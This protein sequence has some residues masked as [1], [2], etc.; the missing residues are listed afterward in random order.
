MLLIDGDILLYSSCYSSMSKNH[1]YHTHLYNL[2][3]NFIC[4]FSNNS[5][6]EYFSFLSSNEN[7]RKK[8]DKSYKN[9]RKEKPI[10][11][12]ETREFL[13]QKFNFIEYPFLEADD[14]I[15]ITK[16]KFFPDSTI[17]SIDKDLYQ[18]D[19]NHYNLRTEKKTKISIKDSENNLLKQFIIGDSVDNI[20]GLKGKGK[21]YAEN[22]L[23][24]NDSKSYKEKLRLIYELYN[25]EFLN[26]YINY[27]NL[28]LKSNHPDFENYIESMKP[29]VFDYTL[30]IE[31][32]L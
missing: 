13:K 16:R 5:D 18:I 1:D 28:K 24:N 23:K 30:P 6:K 3:Y 4:I 31:Y 20:K 2:I 7:Y 32:Y 15:N 12:Q 9:N 26:F 8:I 10:Y 27:L 17:C 22:F 19:G 29:F 25:K 14:C 11:F 21:V